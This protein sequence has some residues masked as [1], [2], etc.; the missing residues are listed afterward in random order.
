M[1]KANGVDTFAKMAEM[2]VDQYK[3]LLKANNMSKFRN[4][5]KW[6]S[7]AGELAKG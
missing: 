6:A 1:L 7:L 3:E 4:P 5:T 2:S